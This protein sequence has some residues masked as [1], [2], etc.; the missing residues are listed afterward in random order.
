M[1]HS[2]ITEQQFREVVQPNSLSKA[3]FKSNDDSDAIVAFTE[4]A[5]L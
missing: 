5:R 2:E 4:A 1:S 3:C